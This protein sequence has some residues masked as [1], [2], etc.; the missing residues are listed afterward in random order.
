VTRT[1][2]NAPEARSDGSVLQIRRDIRMI[3][4]WAGHAS[5]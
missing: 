5:R 2:A 1:N 4:S 3:L